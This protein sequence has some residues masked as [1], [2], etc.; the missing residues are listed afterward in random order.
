MAGMKEL[1]EQAKAAGIPAREIRSA[2]SGAELR[3]M[4][5]EANGSG[6]RKARKSVVKKAVARKATPKR[7]GPGRPKGSKNKTT[8]TATRKSTSRKSTS[9]K[10]STSNGNGGRFLLGKINWS[11]R[12][13]WNPREGSVPDQIVKALK[14]AKGN[15]ESA[16]KALRKS[17]TELVPVRTRDGRKR[18]VGEREDYLRYLISR[19][20]W[21]FALAT[22]QHE[23]APNRVEYG[24]GGTGAGIFKPA[25]KKSTTRKATGTRK[26]A[27]RGPGRPKGS[28]NAPKATAKRRGRPPGSKNK[29]KT[30][31]RRTSRR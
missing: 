16:Y 13:N 3:K 31:A 6:S 28:K 21:A 20:A 7:R 4:I 2:E 8:A 14:K 18:N 17:L 1:R 30:R 25:R 22:E 29:P 5:R 24:T 9:R 23:T 10:A 12:G 19:N 15:R 11:K 27:K 26:S